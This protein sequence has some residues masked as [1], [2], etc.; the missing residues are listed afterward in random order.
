MYTLILCLFI[1][2]LFPYLSK[3]PVAMAMK[4]QVGGYDNNHPRL[5]QATLTG[6]GARAIAAYQNSF[7]SLLI[8]AIA[9]L[10]AIAT[11][12]TSTTVQNLAILYLV[13]RGIYHLLYLLRFQS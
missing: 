13:S 3:I 12:H 1:A 8:F 5:Q 10:T 7:E 9:I 6:L 11:Q 2:C 4:E